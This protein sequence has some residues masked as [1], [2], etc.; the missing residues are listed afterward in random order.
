MAT[1]IRKK[2]VKSGSP[3]GFAES[4]TRQIRELARAKNL[5]G[6]RKRHT[7]SARID[8]N[9]VA[10]AKARTGITS[11]TELVEVALATLAVE[12]DFGEWL[13]SQGGRLDPDF[14]TDL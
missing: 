5:I 9:L 2:Q 13:L 14:D 3:I 8:E 4:K 12:D 11:D 6:G 7:V 10:A 1:V